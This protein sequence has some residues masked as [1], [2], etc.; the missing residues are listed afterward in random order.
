MDTM[1]IAAF[2]GKYSDFRPAPLPELAAAYFAAWSW[3][4]SDFNDETH[5][6]RIFD[7][8]RG[9]YDYITKEREWQQTANFLGRVIGAH[10]SF[11]ESLYKEGVKSFPSQP[12]LGEIV[13]FRF[14]RNGP[15]RVFG[16]WVV[17][18]GALH[19][20]LPFVTGPLAATSD[21]QPAPHGLSG[22]AAPVQQIYPCLVPFFELDEGETIAAADGA[23]EIRPSADGQAVTSIFKHWVVP[24]AKAGETVDPGLVTEVTWS[25][26]GDAIRRAEVVTALRERKVRRIWMAVP[27]RADHIETSYANGKRTDRL[28]SKE[29]VL[30][31]RVLGSNWPAL[32]TGDDPLGR[33]ARG[34]IPLHLMLETARGLSLAPR[35]SLKW[36]IEIS[37]VHTSD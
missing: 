15:G 33:G 11:M 20:S 25:I 23:D 22:F 27:T 6:L 19:F 2:L 31:I 13:R 14:F 24:G 7:F 4:R 21:Y 16:V 1:E 12:K 32:A 30:D 37:C 18:Q 9:N 36:E 3:L 34:A 8:G 10:G 26:F 28:T 5:L 35:G 29:G 17:R